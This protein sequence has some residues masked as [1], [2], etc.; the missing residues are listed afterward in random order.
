MMRYEALVNLTEWA[1]RQGVHHVTAYRWF[2][3]DKLPVPARGVDRLILVDPAATAAPVAETV[4]VYARVSGSDRDRPTARRDIHSH[5]H[6]S[7]VRGNGC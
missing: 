5:A 3:E 6:Q 1:E 4:A 7:I 2:R